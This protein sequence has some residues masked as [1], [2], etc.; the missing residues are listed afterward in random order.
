MRSRGDDERGRLLDDRHMSAVEIRARL[1]ELAE[2][3]MAAEH[4]GLDMDP[5]YMADLELEMLE[6]RR[7]LVGALVTEIAVYRGELF[8]RSFG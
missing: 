1:I 2:E 3:R 5:A 8:G 7:A 6:C 4:A